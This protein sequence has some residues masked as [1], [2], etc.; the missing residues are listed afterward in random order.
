MLILVTNLYVFDFRHHQDY[1]SA[2]PIK[3][4]FDFRQAV[5]AATNLYGYALLITT[6]KISIF[7]DGQSQFDLI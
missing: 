3:V 6:E 2:Q 7:S 4:R 1:K 5:P